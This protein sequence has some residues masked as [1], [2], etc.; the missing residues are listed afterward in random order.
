[1]ISFL[2]SCDTLSPLILTAVSV[3]LTDTDQ[4][5]TSIP[6]GLCP[7]WRWC[8][9]CHPLKLQPRQRSGGPEE[10]VTTESCCGHLVAEEWKL[11][12]LFDGKTD[13]VSSIYILLYKV[14]YCY[15]IVIIELY[16]LLN[17]WRFTK[18]GTTN[19]C[20]QTKRE[21]TIFSLA[22]LFIAIMF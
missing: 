20:T 9:S 18:V 2:F 7:G 17:L 13:N 22:L 21:N 15:E 3:E 6:Q 19:K 11:Q 1:M 12:S 5:F 10:E 16:I 8:Q 4:A 14:E